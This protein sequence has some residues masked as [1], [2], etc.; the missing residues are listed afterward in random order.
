MGLSF[1]EK[2]ILTKNINYSEIKYRNLQNIN[3]VHDHKSR[4]GAFLRLLV[5]NVFSCPFHF[6]KPF[7]S[8]YLLPFMFFLAVVKSWVFNYEQS[9]EMGP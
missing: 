8:R 6:P 3:L 4:F 2:A 7:L 9:L 5:L 1:S